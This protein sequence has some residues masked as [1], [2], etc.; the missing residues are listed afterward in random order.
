MKIRP[1]RKESGSVLAA[2]LCTV[3]IMGITLAAYLDLVAAQNLSI[4]RSQAWNSAIPI[5]ECGLEEALAHLYQ[6]GTNLAVDGWTANAS[7]FSKFRYAGDGWAYVTISNTTPPVIYSRGFA[8]V[9]L[10]TNDYMDRTVRVTTTGGSL[11][12]RGL[13]AKGKITLSGGVRTDSFDS[14]NT[15]YSTA[16]RYDAAKYRDNGDVATD[17]S[18]VGAIT[19]S[20]GVA[21]YGHVNI[22]GG[23][24]ISTSGNV[25][26]GS[27]TFIDGGGTGI[28][29]GYASSNMNVAFPDV[30]APFSGG[31][32]TPGGGT[33]G[34]T[35][36][37]YVIGAGNNQLTSVSMSGQQKA[38]VTG[39]AVLYVTGNI[40][41]SGQSFLYI[42]PGATL[43]LYVAGASASLS[44]QGVANAN[45]NA[46][47]F[48]YY[49]LPSNTSLSLSGNSAFTGVIYAPQADFS[50]SG[51]G[52]N[53]YD[54]VGAAI[55]NTIKMSGH[56][57]FH[58]DENLSRLNLGRDYVVTSW[59]EL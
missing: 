24:T 32:V 16:G 18:V 55:V 31:A 38:I 50:M 21:I 11:F 59:D 5:I 23:G 25:A 19:D 6:N 42:A 53:T 43:K 14:A 56:F 48:F 8:P 20:G 39:N 12:S 57:N 37:A 52:N 22:G 15:N 3:A 28:Q 26:I 35:N 34:G 45:A 54:L 46:T 7:G 2:C 9:P 49:G 33:V 47:N 51:G 30:A 58:Y 10:R 27:R 44:G 4:A 13:V 41:F 36:Y 1:S 40:S 17:S 29:P